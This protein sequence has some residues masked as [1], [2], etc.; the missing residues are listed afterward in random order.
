MES[1]IVIRK[2]DVND[3]K[4]GF[5][6]CLGFLTKIENV[7]ELE[8]QEHFRMLQAKG[9]YLIYVAEDNDIIVGCGTLMIEYKFIRGL[10]KKGHI[11]DIVVRDTHRKRGIGINIIKK[12]LEKSKEIGCYKT[13][14][15]CKDENIKFYE[16][17]G[18]KVSEREMVIYHNK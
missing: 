8:F 4:K 16:K 17:C 14:L 15:C 11:E 18:F 6:E 3:Y 1:N 12:L 13:A 2:L 5:L 10:A 7:T 9:D